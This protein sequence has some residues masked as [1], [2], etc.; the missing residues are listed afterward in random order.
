[1]RIYKV[2]GLNE[3]GARL[4]GMHTGDG[5]LYKTNSNSIVWELR[6]SLSE[7]EFYDSFVC[8]FLTS[9]FKINI[10][11]KF[12]SGGANGCYGIQTTNKNIIEF[13]IRNGF[14]PGSK[15]HTVR[16]PELIM[17]SK[18]EIKHA[19][20]SGLFDTD[21]CIRLDKNKTK[22]HYYP[23]IEF[24]FASKGLRDDLYKLLAELG[25][26]SYIWRSREDYKI[27]LAGFANRD[28][29]FDEVRPMNPKHFKRAGLLEE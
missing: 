21:G 27:C 15:V 10:T 7:K 28:K 9:L 14:Q 17:H 19:F 6:G 24:G 22:I 2:M 8:P 29:W 26:K 12:R 3:Y 1:M 13:L 16:I 20:I 11:A 18:N 5:T 23:K 25:F 4:L